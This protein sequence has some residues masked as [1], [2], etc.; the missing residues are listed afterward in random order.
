[1]KKITIL[2]ADDH[3]IVRE[4]IRAL[5]NAEPDMVVVGEA[6]NGRHALRALQKFQPEVLVV[7]I[8]MPR[9]GGIETIQR[10][11]RQLPQVKI[12]VLSMYADDEYVFQATEAGATGYLV[13]GS[14][15]TE[16]VAA[17]REA[18][19]GRAY[20]SSAVSQPLV[21]DLVGKRGQVGVGPGHH[22]LT[23]REREVLQLIA[24]GLSNKEISRELTISVKTVEK[25]RQRIMDKLNIHSVVGLTRHAIQMGMVRV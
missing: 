5:L 18:M 15:A 6:E 2:L 10:V 21:Q 9:L 7:D 4:G 19:R 12:L 20:F 3:T 24:E 1:M 16:L 11:R 13:K 8:A 25:H 23:P 17:I 14:P 22:A